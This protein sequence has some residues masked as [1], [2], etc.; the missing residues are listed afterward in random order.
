[1]TQHL[2]GRCG[3]GRGSSMGMVLKAKV[4]KTK[5]INCSHNN[6]YTRYIL[7]TIKLL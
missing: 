1:M 7:H 2:K 3:E 5:I 4:I 6:A